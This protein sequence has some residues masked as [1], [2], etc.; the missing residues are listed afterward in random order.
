MKFSMIMR[1]VPGNLQRISS[2]IA[3][4]GANVILVQ[5][6][7]LNSNLQLNEAILHVAC[8]VSGKEHGDQVIQRLE[9]AGY[10]TLM[11]S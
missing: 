2:V 5:H 9:T 3:D 10:R 11:E 7:R 4:C 6:D 1:D 8:E